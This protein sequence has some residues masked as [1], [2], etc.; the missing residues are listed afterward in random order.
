MSDLMMLGTN[1]YPQRSKVDTRSVK[2]TQR[3]VVLNARLIYMT[4]V[5]KLS[6]AIRQLQVY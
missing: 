6:I 1:R 5:F 4:N 2:R 3:A